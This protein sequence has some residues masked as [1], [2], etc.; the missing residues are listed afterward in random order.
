MR[1]ITIMGLALV[2][3]LATSALAAG[4]AS[5]T[6]KLDFTWGVGEFQLKPGDEFSVYTLDLTIETSIGNVACTSEGGFAGTDLTNDEKTDKVELKY[7]FGDLAFGAPCTNS[8]TFAGEALVYI[9]GSSPLGTL[10]LGSN[11]KAGF[12]ALS[13]SEPVKVLL[14]FVTIEKKCLYTF[15]KL[16]GSVKATPSVALVE[17]KFSKQKLKLAKPTSAPTCPKTATLTAT[18]PFSRTQGGAQGIGEHTH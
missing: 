17:A 13:A 16:K 1:R 3:V 4:T 8:T 14:F 10:S 5:A 7:A 6:S 18:S 11:G 9:S 15:T 12:T 2:A